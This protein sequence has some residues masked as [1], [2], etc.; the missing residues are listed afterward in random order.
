MRGLAISFLLLF[1][2]PAFSQTDH[3]ETV[4]KANEQ[5]RYFIGTTTPPA[6]EPAANWRTAAFDDT[7]WFAGTGGIGYGDGDDG[8]TLD[9]SGIQ[10]MS[11]FLRKKFT[12]VDKSKIESG[13]LSVDYDD[14]FVA[15]LNGTEIARANMNGKGDF[16]AYNLNSSGFGDEALVTPLPFPIDR[17]KLHSILVQGENTLAVQVHNENATSSDLTSNVY[18]S[19]GINDASFTYQSTPDWFTAPADFS[20]DLPIIV[21]NT[22]GGQSIP[23]DPKIIATMGVIAITFLIRSTITTVLLALKH[24]VSHRRCFQKNLIRSKPRTRLARILM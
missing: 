17:E 16:P 14:G 21:I 23:D 10:V 4:I 9:V 8:T 12:I 22:T 7:G 3:W 1:S 19:V 2:L 15:Y 20:S 11:V 13:I 24:A 5:W 18:L 6:V